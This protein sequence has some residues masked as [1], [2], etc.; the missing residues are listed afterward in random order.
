MRVIILPILVLMS[1]CA[2]AQKNKKDTAQNNVLHEVTIEG[3]ILKTPKI[4]K[5]GIT[6]MDLPQ[7]ITILD[8]KTLQQQQISNLTDVLKNVNGVY[9]MGNTGGYQEEIASRGSNISSTNTFN[10]SVDV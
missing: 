5:N 6:E 1:V 10:A 9:I 2:L 4:S 8:G 3:S 7:A